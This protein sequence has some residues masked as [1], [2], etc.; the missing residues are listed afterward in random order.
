MIEAIPG[1]SIGRLIAGLRRRGTRLAARR[2]Q[3][4]TPPVGAT[5]DAWRSPERLWPDLF[6]EME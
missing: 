4:S 5:A 3:R 6:E 1:R 2:L